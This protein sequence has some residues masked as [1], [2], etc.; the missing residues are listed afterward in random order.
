M[1]INRSDLI[2]FQDSARLLAGFT[3][4]PLSLNT[5]FSEVSMQQRFLDLPV[6]P[7]RLKQ[8]H[9]TL[10]FKGDSVAPLIDGDGL[11]TSEKNVLLITSHADCVPLYLYSDNLI[12]LSHC[13][14]AGT[15]NGMVEKSLEIML[16]G[17]EPG[18]IKA[19]IGPG[20]CGKCYEVGEAVYREFS[21]RYRPDSPEFRVD[22]PRVIKT[23]LINS[24]IPADNITSSGLCTCHDPSFFSFRRDGTKMRNAAFFMLKS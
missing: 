10:I 15:F 22:L 17:S 18:G 21:T 6:V 1:S 3:K 14:R 2:I 16:S 20:I 7:V 13:G 5:L 24:G 12:L 23:I 19:L 4:I 11:Y 8:I 9:S